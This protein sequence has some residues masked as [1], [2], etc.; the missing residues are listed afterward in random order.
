MVVEPPPLS[1]SMNANPGPTFTTRVAPPEGGGVGSGGV[2]NGGGVGV[3]DPGWVTGGGGTR[4]GCVGAE[5]LLWQAAARRKREEQTAVGIQAFMIT[6]AMRSASGSHCGAMP[7][8]C[9]RA[10]S[11]KSF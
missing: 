2:G 8:A 9:H 4:T 1:E 3:G 5:S 10:Q 11:L 7:C 6:S